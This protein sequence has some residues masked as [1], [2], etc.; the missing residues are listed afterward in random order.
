MPADETAPPGPWL[1]TMGVIFPLAVVLI[2]LATGL[3]AEILFDPLPTW[4]H[5]VVVLAVPAIN[6]ILW[7]AARREAPEPPQR[8]IMVAAGAGAAISAAYALLFLPLLPISLIAIVFLGVGLLPQAPALALLANVKLTGRL[9][10]DGSGRWRWFGGVLAGLLALAAVDLPATATFVAL[11][12]SAGD[13]AAVRR[14]TALMRSVGDEAMLLRLCYG[15]AGRATGL[16]SFLVSSWGDGLFAAGRVESTGAARELYYRATGNAFNAAE[17]PRRARLFEFDEDQGGE[18]VGGQVEGLKLA[19]SRLDGSISTSDNVGYVEWTARF[20]NSSPVQREARLTLALPPG[21]VAS[22][23]TLWVNGEPREASI[24]GRGE[25]RAAYE[26]VVSARRDPLLVTTSGAGR[27]L[28]QAFPVPPGA[29]LK[30]RIGV[31]APLEIAADGARSLTLP[32]LAERNFVVPAELRHELWIEGDAPIEDGPASFRTVIG[33]DQLERRPSLRTAPIAAPATRTA[34]VPA[35]GKAPALAIVQTIARAPAPPPRSLVL[36]LDG[37][38]SNRDGAAGLVRALDAVPAGI[39]VALFIAADDP[40]HVPLAPWSAVQ[41]RRLEQAVSDTA[42]I[43]GQDNLGALAD[44]LDSARGADSVL[45]W[46]HGP[47]PVAFA[48]SRGRVEQLLERRRDLP[49]LVRYQPRSGPAFAIAGAS[50]FEGAAETVPSGD[51]AR[52]LA[53]V[54]A[55]LGGGPRWRVT[56]TSAAAPDGP[57][58]SLHVARL[59]GT[60]AAAAA[61]ATPGTGREEAIALARRLN[62]VTP[63][64]GAVVLETDAQTRANGLA[65]PDAADVPTVP[66]PGFWIMLAI[67]AL[68]SAGLLRRRRALA[69]A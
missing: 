36:L 4:G 30:L 35:A 21:G 60:Q 47:Q 5:T 24:A 16:V 40:R 15:D 25:A 6:F 32:A 62:I 45:L 49:R 68:L 56:R 27:L 2:E 34:R 43:G 61:A 14:G 17:P 8:W 7:K 44:A 67:V 37:S 46:I 39:P 41:R 54:I 66:E 51:A 1:L 59:W 19:D 48:R 12:W 65:V 10:A 20:E 26:S 18:T 55:D 52:D 33:N 64:S 28:V 57:A 50:W 58:S 31:S 69:F 29:S 53:S 9:I 42:F 23:A 22:R 3:S 63:V 11:R 13:E 38:A